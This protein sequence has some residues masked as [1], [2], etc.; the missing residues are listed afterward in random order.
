[1]SE[2]ARQREFDIEMRTIVGQIDPESFEMYINELYTKHKLI[3]RWIFTIYN[4]KRKLPLDHEIS[5]THLEVDVQTNFLIFQKVYGYEKF[6]FH[7]K[8]I[9]SFNKRKIDPEVYLLNFITS[10]KELEWIGIITNTQI[11]DSMIVFAEPLQSENE[12]CS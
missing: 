9:P 2:E 12:E 1:M 3:Y 8:K 7:V 5:R 10:Q 6:K 4:L 11:N